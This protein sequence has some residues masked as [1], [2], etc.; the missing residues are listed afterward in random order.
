MNWPT[1]IV[2]IEQEIVRARAMLEQDRATVATSSRPDIRRIFARTTEKLC[3][4]LER[5][6]RLA[7]ATGGQI[8]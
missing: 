4:D 8:F 6:L 1:D 3:T 7:R 5:R 2:E